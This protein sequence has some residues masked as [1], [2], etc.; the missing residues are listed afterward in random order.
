MLAFFVYFG[1]VMKKIFVYITCEGEMFYITNGELEL[2]G[3]AHIV[4]DGLDEFVGA[5]T[6]EIKLK[7]QLKMLLSAYKFHTSNSYTE[8]IPLSVFKEFKNPADDMVKYLKECG[9]LG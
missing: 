2:A 5:Y 4:C 3:A 1:D 8:L 6:D 7:E 9:L